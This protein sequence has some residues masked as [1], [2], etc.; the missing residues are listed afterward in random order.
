[1]SQMRCGISDLVMRAIVH[2]QIDNKALYGAQI[3]IF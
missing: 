3:H 2:S 1:M